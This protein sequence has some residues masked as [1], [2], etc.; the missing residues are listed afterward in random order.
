MSQEAK[1]IARKAV[2]EGRKNLTEPESRQVLAQYDIPVVRGM[3]AADPAEAV[4]AAGA[5]GYPVALKVCSPDIIHKTEAG[6]VKL[7][8][9]DAGQVQAA[10]AEIREKVQRYRPGARW[11]GVLV[12]KMAPPGG[13]ELVIGTSLDASFGPVVMAGLGGIM[14]EVLKDV[15]FR[16][17]P[18]SP[19]ESRTMLK[20]IRAYPLLL[21]FRGR[22]GVDL[23][24]V[25]DLI[26]RVSRLAVDLEEE[27]AEIDL[28]PVMAYP[29]GVEVLDCR[30][31]CR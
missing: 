20:E 24:Q 6:G 21:S 30:V 27:V 7:D 29:W 9:R 23:Q 10:F 17:A 4:E 31:I 16:V 14:V 25:C 12:T 18:V 22:P 13:V 26:S 15:A 3:L 19:A 5:L 11:Q 8:L 1:A 2:R 28:N